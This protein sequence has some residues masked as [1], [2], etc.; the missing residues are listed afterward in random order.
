MVHRLFVF[1]LFDVISKECDSRSGSVLW[2]NESCPQ[3]GRLDREGGSQSVL[4]V[5]QLLL[6]A[7]KVHF[8]GNMKFQTV[9]LSR[10]ENQRTSNPIM[11][12]LRLSRV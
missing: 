2:T 1:Q 9:H 7:K 5:L 3:D 10:I 6:T 4:F 8:N 12:K 11:E